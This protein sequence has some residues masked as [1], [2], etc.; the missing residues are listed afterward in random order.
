MST[1]NRAGSGRTQTLFLMY[2][3]IK[4]LWKEIFI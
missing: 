2:D 3:A 4:T 1:S